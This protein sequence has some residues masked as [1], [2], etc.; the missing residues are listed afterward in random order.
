MGRS[1]HGNGQNPDEQRRHHSQRH[2]IEGTEKLQHQFR[3]LRT[4]ETR[5]PGV[6]ALAEKGVQ[7]MLAGIGLEQDFRSRGKIR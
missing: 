3:R 6:P 5:A 4:A 1:G 2:Q 7:N